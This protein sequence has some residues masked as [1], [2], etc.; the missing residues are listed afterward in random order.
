MVTSVKNLGGYT[1]LY[2]YTL[3]HVMI[4]KIIEENMKGGKIK[5]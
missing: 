2:S 3:V 1:N 5:S 4:L